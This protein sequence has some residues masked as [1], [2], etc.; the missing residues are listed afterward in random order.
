MELRVEEEPRDQNVSESEWIQCLSRA[1]RSDS[2]LSTHYSTG[3]CENLRS[4]V[5]NVIIKQS[6]LSSE[7]FP[8]SHNRTSSRKTQD[9]HKDAHPKFTTKR[10]EAMC[11]IT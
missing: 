4:L 5:Q 8:I 2:T 6:L 11:F 10:R 1:I 3:N 7:K 9:E